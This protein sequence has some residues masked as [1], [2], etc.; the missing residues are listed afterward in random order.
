MDER[1]C[2]KVTCHEEAVATLTYVYADS[3]VV[4][5]PLSGRVEPHGYDLCARHAA[6]LSAPQGWQV[7]RRVVLG[8][9]L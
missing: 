9:E 7:L 4:V 2:S 3:M 5:G 1:P 8:H 6:S